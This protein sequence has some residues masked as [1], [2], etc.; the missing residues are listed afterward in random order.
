MDYE[1][2]G[3]HHAPGMGGRRAATAEE[4]GKDLQA[5]RTWVLAEA[6]L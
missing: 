3:A 4:M 5:R 1:L 6:L 2:L